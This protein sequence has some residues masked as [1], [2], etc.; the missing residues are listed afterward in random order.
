MAEA[1]N[2]IYQAFMQVRANGALILDKDFMMKI[3][4]PVVDKVPELSGFLEWHFKKKRTQVYGLFTKDSMKLGV[5]IVRAEFFIPASIPIE[6][7]LKFVS[8]LEKKLVTSLLLNA[9]IPVL[10]KLRTNTLMNLTIP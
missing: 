10:E 6:R 5:D 3:L 9:R 4:L 7:Q 8:C 2:L 1:I